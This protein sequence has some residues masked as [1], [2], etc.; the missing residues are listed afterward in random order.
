VNF[1]CPLNNIPE[2]VRKAYLEKNPV[3]GEAWK[4]AGKVD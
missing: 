2:N 1:S 4:K 3:M